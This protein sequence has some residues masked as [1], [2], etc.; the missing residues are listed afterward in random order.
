LSPQT[1]R[2]IVHRLSEEFWQSYGGNARV[3]DEFFAPDYVNHD[4]ST[5]AVHGREE[6][7]RWALGVRASWARAFPDYRITIEDLIA[8]DDRVAKRWTLRG[9]H[10]G[11]FM[12]IAPTR[13]QV[14]MRGVA[15]YCF[16]AARVKDIWWNYDAAGLMQQL[17]PAG[18]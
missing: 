3:I 15:I 18:R 13:K 7:K 5:P 10:T 17:A 14:M 11:E 12:G 2:H 6:F 4:L 1:N 8:E 16:S 9:T